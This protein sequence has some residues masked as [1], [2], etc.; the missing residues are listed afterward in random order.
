MS[1][2]N[3]ANTGGVGYAVIL[4]FIFVVLKL[5]HCGDVAGWSWVWVL[6]PFWISLLIWAAFA[7]VALFLIAIIRSGQK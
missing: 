7:T 3:S 4:T 1:Q 2:N 6:S 5:T